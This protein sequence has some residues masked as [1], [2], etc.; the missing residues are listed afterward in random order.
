MDYITDRIE[1][2][3]ANNTSLKATS[4]LESILNF[5]CTGLFGFIYH[6]PFINFG[7]ILYLTKK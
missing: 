5:F 7:T 1:M 2:F 4:V 3:L 6:L